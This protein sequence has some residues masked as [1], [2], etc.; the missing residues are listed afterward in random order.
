MGLEGTFKK[1]ILQ[2]AP[3]DWLIQTIETMTGS[4]VPDLFFCTKGY[5][6]W[7][8]LKATPSKQENLCYLRI[9]QWRWFC[10]F[11]SRG[12][13]GFLIIKRDK[14]KRV[15]I[16]LASHLT[17]VDASRDCVLKGDDIIMPQS[18]KPVATYKLGSGNGLFFTRLTDVF[19]KEY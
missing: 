16:Y 12:G 13:F 8:E 6:G 4:G 15:D 3:K 2:N 19:K 9:S 7:M 18:I 11:I 10:K 14:L 1:W 5:Q 17:H